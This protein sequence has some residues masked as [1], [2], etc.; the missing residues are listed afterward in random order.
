MDT[1]KVAVRLNYNV[2]QPK[3]LTQSSDLLV[4][5]PREG[6]ITLLGKDNNLIF[7]RLLNKPFTR[8]A[9]NKSSAATRIGANIH[10][11]LI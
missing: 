9:L 4:S 7:T 6:K 3:S 11:N 1:I 2:F 5:Q 8:T 10:S